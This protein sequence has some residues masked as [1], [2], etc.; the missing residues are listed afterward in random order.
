MNDKHE[1]MLECIHTYIILVLCEKP[2]SAVYKVSHNT[3]N[4][5]GVVG[6]P[7]SV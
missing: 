7:A 5:A 4:E 6:Q 1:H 3:E 2:L